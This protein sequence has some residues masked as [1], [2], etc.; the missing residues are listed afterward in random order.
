MKY[1]ARINMSQTN[2]RAVIV[3]HEI[4]G[5]NRFI[6]NKRQFLRET[7]YDVFCPDLLGRAAF[8]YENSKKAYNYFVQ[9]IGFE[10]YKEINRFITQLKESYEKV[11][12][13]GFSIGATIAWRCC[14]N[15]L[16]DGMIACYGSRIRDYTSLNPACPMLLLFAKEDAFDVEAVVCQLQ[17]KA[18]LEMLVF[19]ARHGFMDCYSGS[20]DLNAALQA[21]KKIDHFLEQL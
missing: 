2:Q 5:I 1:V 12:V 4:Y 17:G 15:P 20:F 10:I 7:G 18:N 8:S 21:E 14:E 11:A 13:V 6:K 16:C 3:L 19:A 9:Q